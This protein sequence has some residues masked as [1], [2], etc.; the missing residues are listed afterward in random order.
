VIAEYEKIVENESFGD[1]P[2]PDT[3]PDTNHT[4]VCKPSKDFLQP[5]SLLEVCL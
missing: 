4:S 1:D 2:P 3:I 5:L